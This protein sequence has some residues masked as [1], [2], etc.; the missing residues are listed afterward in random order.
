MPYPSLSPIQAGGVRSSETP[1][2][3]DILT[4][5]YGSRM[6][7]VTTAETYD[8]AIDF[9]QDEFLELKDVER[10]RIRLAVRVVLTGNSPGRRQSAEI[11][12]SAW[13]AV[14]SALAR[15]EI[16]EIQ[17]V[18]PPAAPSDLRSSVA[19]PPPSYEKGAASDMKVSA[20]ATNLFGSGSQAQSQSQSQSQSHLQPQSLTNRLV[21][22]CFVNED[23]MYCPSDM[24]SNQFVIFVDNQL[25]RAKIFICIRSTMSFPCSND[26][27]PMKHRSHGPFGW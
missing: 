18:E 15:F 2:P 3:P 6:V 25:E 10:G 5:C 19:E 14:V 23:I 26:R 17:L 8:Q 1:S 13:S 20:T 7:Y 4:Y 22:V 11:G 9:A 24:V 12:R 27:S 21:G 16:I